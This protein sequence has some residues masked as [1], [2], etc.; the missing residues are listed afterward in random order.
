MANHRGKR[1][2]LKQTRFVL[3]YVANG[4][5]GTQAAIAAGYTV[6]IAPQQAAENLRKQ[7]IV[8]AIEEHEHSIAEA[9]GITPE[10]LAT[11]IMNEAKGVAEDST[12]NGRIAAMRLLSDFVGKF[13]KNKQ[14]L[15]HSG[16]IDLS[17]KSDAELEEM[18][19]DLDN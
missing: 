11:M 7:H 13:D 6:K 15:E 19:K 8:D 14:R 9:A 18:L 5:N 1:L 2:T 3:E 16:G 12:Q 10:R 17:G 4:G